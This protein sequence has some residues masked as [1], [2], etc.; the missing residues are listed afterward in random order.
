MRKL[1]VILLFLIGAVALDRVDIAQQQEN[2]KCEILDVRTPQLANALHHNIDAERTSS[3]VVPSVRVSS[4]STARYSHNR[5]SLALH[6][7]G[8]AYSSNYS[9]SRFVLRLGSFA[10][11]VD[12]YLYMLCVLR[13]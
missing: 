7:G 3:V 4:S 6:S 8:C 10:R 12:Y 2:V 5:V 1:W 11:V 13:L 9:A